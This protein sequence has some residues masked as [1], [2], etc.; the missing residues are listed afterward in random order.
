MAEINNLRNGTTVGEEH[1]IDGINYIWDG[2]VWRIQSPLFSVST[3]TTING[4]GTP[5]SPLSI[6]LSLRKTDLF[7][8]IE[9]AT[10]S[11]TLNGNSYNYTEYTTGN[12]MY[13]FVDGAALVN[14]S[15]VSGDGLWTAVN[16]SS[17]PILPTNSANLIG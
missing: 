14:G 6:S 4:N 16:P 3:D 15:V 12:V 9:G 11:A 7:L 8:G 13:Y 10:A 2:T 17:D 1:T 5:T